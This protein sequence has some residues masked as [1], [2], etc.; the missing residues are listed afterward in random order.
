MTELIELSVIAKEICNFLSLTFIDKVGEGAYKETFCVE[1]DTNK[2]FA[3]KIFK[4]NQV[5]L[6]TEREIEAMKKCDYRGIAKINNIDLFEY[7]GKEYLF[8]LE[9]FYNGG[10]LQQKIESSGL[11]Q[12]K[13]TFLLGSELIKSICHIASHDLVHRDIKPENIL[14]N[15]N[16]SDP[17]ITDFGIVRDLNAST[18]TQSWLMNGPCTPFYAAP[19]QLNNEKYLV[20]WR[21][22]QFSLGIT[23]AII[24]FGIHPFKW[25]GYSDIDIITEV[26]NRGVPSLEFMKNINE[27]ELHVLRKMVEGW[28]SMRYRKPSDLLVAWEK[29]RS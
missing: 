5:D 6:R 19:E 22:D 29:Q 27:S 17:I 24:A 21:T 10:T 13:E 11:F 16:S 4:T 15:I 2:S 3:L 14:F 1:E 8:L 25:N 23:L 12:P 9:N 26:A 18:I 20:D 28:P 7:D